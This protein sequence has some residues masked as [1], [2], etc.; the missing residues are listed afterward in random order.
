MSAASDGKRLDANALG[1]IRAVTSGERGA[2]AGFV[3]YSRRCQIVGAICE[4]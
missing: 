3:A 2:I 4:D 1:Y